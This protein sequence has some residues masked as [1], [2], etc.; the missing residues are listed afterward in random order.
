[1]AY[2]YGKPVI[3]ADVGGLREVVE[4]GVSGRMV[5]PGDPSALASVIRDFLRAPGAITR[6]GV[7]KVGR[8]M[9]WDSLAECL[10]DLIK[11]TGE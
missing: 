2:H 3:A 8:R 10:L 1:L 7:E 6:E 11:D 9:T 5:R 4:D